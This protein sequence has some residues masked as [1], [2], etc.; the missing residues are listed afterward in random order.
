MGRTA[1]QTDQHGQLLVLGGGQGLARHMLAVLTWGRGQQGKESALSHQQAKLQM[2]CCPA[3]YQCLTQWEE[4]LALY[5]S[6]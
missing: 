1:Q 6:M 3:L 4:C 2:L 5:S